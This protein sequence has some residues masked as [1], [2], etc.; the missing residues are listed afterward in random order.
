MIVA[1]GL[2][3]VLEGIIPFLFP[4][5]WRDTINRIARLTDGQIRFVGLVAL[6]CGL[7]VLVLVH[8]FS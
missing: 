7:V 1:I 6:S 2:M 3:L 8:I 4:R 5:H